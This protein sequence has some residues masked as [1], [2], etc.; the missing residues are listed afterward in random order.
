[1]PESEIRPKIVRESETVSE[2]EPELETKPRL[3]LKHIIMYKFQ[4]LLIINNY[5]QQIHLFSK[6]GGTFF[7]RKKKKE[8]SFTVPKRINLLM[9]VSVHKKLKHTSRLFICS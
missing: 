2:S 7:F 3:R 4:C 9:R 1:M 8:I 6:L 5:K